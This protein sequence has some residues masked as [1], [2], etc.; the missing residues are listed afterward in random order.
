MSFVKGDSAYPLSPWLM[1]K[2]QGG[3]LNDLQR[4]FNRR[5]AR[6]RQVVERCIGILKMRFRC[7]LGERKLRYNP[8]RV[9]Q[10]IYAC[11]TLHNYLIVNRFDIL[12]GI[13]NQI[14]DNLMNQRNADPVPQED[15]NEIAE[16][17]RNRLSVFLMR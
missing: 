5:L 6:V 14:L 4:N 7:L 3:N 16:N 1:K 9:G 13:N 17:R 8:M 10:I 15:L 12:H 2:Y 11:A